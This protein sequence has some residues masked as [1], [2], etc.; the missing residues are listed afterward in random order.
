MM[1]ISMTPAGIKVAKK[2]IQKHKVLH[3]F[4]ESAWRELSRSPRKRL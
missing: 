1:F 4:F 2:V 3:D